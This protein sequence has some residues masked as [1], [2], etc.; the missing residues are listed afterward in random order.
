MRKL[1]QQELDQVKK[2][3]AAKDLTSAEILVEIYDH[4]VSHLESKSIGEFEYELFELE[5]KFTS[6]FCKEMQ[7]DFQENA[8]KE[9]SSLQWSIW[10][11]YFTWPKVLATASFFTIFLLIWMYGVNLSRTL[12]LCLPL[13]FGTCLN[14]WLWYKSYK[15]VSKIRKLLKSHT[16]LESSYLPNSVNQ[17][18]ILFV[19]S[20]LI[21]QVSRGSELFNSSQSLI[22]SISV[23]AIFAAI[24]NYMYSFY[25]ACKLK[26]KTAL[27]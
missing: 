27:I 3:I 5:Q 2:A 10:K 15:R 19:T 17:F 20:N 24:V 18:V 26:S 21:F 9:I 6:R 25:E 13:V 11:S 12:A 1:T 7:L 22:F 4:Y 8:E 23:L 14:G 16:T